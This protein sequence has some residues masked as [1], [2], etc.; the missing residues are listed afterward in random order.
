YDADRT[1]RL[2]QIIRVADQAQIDWEL[3]NIRLAMEQK[4]PVE[5]FPYLKKGV[6]AEVRAGPM[7]GLQ[8]V[9][10]DRTRRDRLVL[11]VDMLGQAVS[12]EV[13]GSLLDP[14]E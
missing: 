11:Q 14:L 6:R 10:A 9:I 4:A 2:A 13:D 12:V 3:S 7:R 5:P 1:R 8:G